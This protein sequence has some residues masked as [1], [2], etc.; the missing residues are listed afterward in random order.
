MSIREVSAEQLAQIFH[1]YNQALE[2]DFIRDSQS[3]GHTWERL[4]QP[5]RRRMIEAARLALLELASTAAEPEEDSRR[6]FAKPGKA[7][8][9]C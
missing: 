3:N 7:E 9:G 4:P 1:H 5:E 8:W 6:Y 2:P